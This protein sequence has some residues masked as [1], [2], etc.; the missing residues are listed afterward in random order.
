[1]GI[2]LGTSMAGWGCGGS[3]NSTFDVPQGETSGAGGDGGGGSAG[4]STAGMGGLGGNVGSAGNGSGGFG[5]NE[6]G[7]ASGSSLDAAVD[8]AAD[9]PD[10]ISQETADGAVTDVFAHADGATDAGNAI[11]V[12]TPG[13]VYCAGMA[14]TLAGL[15]T[16]ICCVGAAPFPTA[17]FP[18][19]PGCVNAG[20]SIIAC[21]DTADCTSGMVCCGS[22]T[23]GVFGAS[24]GTSCSGGT[25]QVCRTD[26]ECGGVPGACSV[27]LE[28]PD[29]GRC[30]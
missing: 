29:F 17:C 20:V 13:S 15:P 25:F 9:A 12:A 10:D 14:C 2:A 22:V 27:A 19:F 8:R 18:S 5:A 4:A 16:N 21:D 30:K 6:G 26:A 1:M 7:G 23:A 24:C 11:G 28:A 3:A